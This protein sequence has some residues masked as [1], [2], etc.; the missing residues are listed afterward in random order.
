MAMSTY[1][2]YRIKLKDSPDELKVQADDVDLDGEGESK[3]YNFLKNDEEDAD[4]DRQTIAAIP[5]SQ[6][7][8]I[9]S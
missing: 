6:V 1:R 5:Y 7:L 3:W 4:E 8:Y 2:N 9:I